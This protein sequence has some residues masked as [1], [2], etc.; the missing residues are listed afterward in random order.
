MKGASKPFIT[1]ILS[2]QLTIFLSSKIR[3]ISAT[4]RF[5]P[6]NFGTKNKS[7]Q[8]LLTSPSPS[9]SAKHI[10]AFRGGA[11]HSSTSAK[12]SLRLKSNRSFLAMASNA[13]TESAVSTTPIPPKP[14]RDE[15]LKV[16]AGNDPSTTFI[17]QSENSQNKLCDPPVPIPNPYGWMR[18]EKRTNTEVLDHLKLENE[19]TNA[20]TNH[21]QPLRESLYN[22]MKGMMQ[23]T[24]FSVPALRGS[25]YLY[26]T[27]T[28]EGKSYSVHCRA[29]KVDDVDVQSQLA[30]WDGNKDSPILN[31]EQVYLDTNQLAEGHDYCSTGSVRMSPSH[32]KVA[33]T[34]DTIG[35]ET[36]KLFVKDVASGEIVYENKEEDMD[37]TVVW[38]KDDSTVFYLKMDDT[39][40]PYQ[41]YQKSFDS[42]EPDK[43]LFE[44]KDELF[45]VHLSKSQDDKYLFISTE[46][47]ETSEIH[48]IS[49]DSDSTEINVI[50]PRRPKV[51]YDVEHHN[52]QFYIMSN[53]GGTPN[54]RLMIC[55]VQSNSQDLWTDLTSTDSVTLFN[56]GY[57]RALDS[58]TPFTNHLVAQGRENGLPRVWVLSLGDNDEVTSFDLLTF[59]EEAHDVGL[60][61]NYIYDTD[62]VR[63]SYDSLVTPAQTIQIPLNDP[64]NAD[65]RIILKKK[66]VPGYDP[67]LYACERT[68]VPS[69]DGSVSIP[70]SIV[71]RKDVLPSDGPVPTHLYGYGS[72]G[73]CIEADFRMT[74]LPLLNRGV[75]YVIAHVRGGGEMGRQWYEEPNGAKY[76]CKK[77]TFTDFVDVAEWL[78][79]DSGKN[80]TNP[81]M[82]SCE[83]RS[84]GGLLIG[85]SINIAPELFKVAVLGVPFVD[86]ACTMIDST[87]P[88]TVVEWEEWGNPNE[89]KF[90]DYICSYSPMENVKEG[91]D[92]PACLLTGGLHDPRVQVR[93]LFHQYDMYIIVF[94]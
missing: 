75:V 83:G 91:A 84:A 73:S 50:A 14:R 20:L 78:V 69:R 81:Q 53:V 29:P 65:T 10:L 26:Y 43:L 19:Y 66:N 27:R 55:P 44:E 11:F 60:G 54:M 28:L 15:S 37:S 33:Y 32:T 6:K 74:R 92:Y 93:F 48:Y 5:V 31:D 35:G 63:V 25:E 85:A 1:L 45:W 71:Y 30:S 79:K 64:N 7:F 18:D 61:S 80:I 46:S 38:G 56:G 12:T 77:N 70:V 82:L 49:L 94:L 41:V 58:I 62:K 40:R 34:L 76:L 17:R 52:N 9:P 88:L 24:D 86:V 90:R 13:E 72:Y 68:T 39:H 47:K 23:E 36:Y 87:I 67:E 2:F 59:P 57:E 22:E 16:F 89:E 3:S 4:A 42:S 21:L 51:L 8:S